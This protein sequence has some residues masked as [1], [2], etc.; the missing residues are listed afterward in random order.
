MNR[1][2][3]ETLE[4]RE[5]L[6]GVLADAYPKALDT[7]AVL[8]ALRTGHGCNY[9]PWDG[10]KVQRAAGQCNSVPPEACRAWCWYHQAYP[11][12]RLLA[13]DGRIEYQSAHRGTGPRRCI[14]T[15]DQ[16]VGDVKDSRVARWRYIPDLG[17]ADLL[18]R[19]VQELD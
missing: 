15:V 19:E 11:Q 13:Q 12:L 14:G 2:R 17:D 9:K 7:H 5:K 1:V 16:V 8:A 10:T 3:A 6:L 4:L 18:Y